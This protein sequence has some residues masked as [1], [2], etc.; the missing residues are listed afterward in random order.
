MIRDAGRRDYN[1][2]R[3]TTDH[4]P[5][6]TIEQDDAILIIY[7]SM[8]QDNY[9]LLDTHTTIITMIIITSSLYTYYTLI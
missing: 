2:T 8:E 9:Y 1:D 3:K 4:R 7:T 5:K 6:Q